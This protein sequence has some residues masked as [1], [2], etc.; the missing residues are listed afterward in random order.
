MK[1]ASYTVTATVPTQVQDSVVR[2]HDLDLP[3]AWWPKKRV[4]QNGGSC[5]Q[6]KS[7]TACSVGEPLSTRSVGGDGSDGVNGLFTV[8]GVAGVRGTGR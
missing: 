4:S 1:T 5:C 6:S 7:L 3:D 2:S 8:E